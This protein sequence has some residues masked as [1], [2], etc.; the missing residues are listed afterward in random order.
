MCTCSRQWV[1]FKKPLLSRLNWIHTLFLERVHLISGFSILVLYCIVRTSI[2][3]L[4]ILSFTIFFH[5]VLGRKKC[6]NLT[7]QLTP[8]WPLLA[9]FPCWFVCR[10]LVCN[11]GISRHSLRGRSFS[12]SHST[13][14]TFS[15]LFFLLF[16]VPLL[17]LRNL[18]FWILYFVAIL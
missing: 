13:M 18:Y 8:R 2:A 17:H 1:L 11:F 15:P 3:Y 14:S 5:G 9:S 16:L 10:L 7:E 12:S 6:N 4:T